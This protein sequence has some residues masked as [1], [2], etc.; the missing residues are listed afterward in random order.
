MEDSEVQEICRTIYQKHRRAL[1]VLFEHRPDRA[2]ELSDCLTQLITRHEDLEEDHCSKSYVR[3]IP[4]QLDF[5]PRVGEGWTR[6]GRMIL[7]E[8]DNSGGSLQLRLI[9]GPGDHKIREAVHR[10]V[11]EHTDVFNRAEKKFTQKWWSFHTEIWV[12]RKQYGE[13]EIEELEEQVTERFRRFATQDLTGIVNT[14]L[15]LR[16]L[17]LNPEH[18]L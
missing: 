7:F 9:L 17:D 3:F 6:S 13:L 8:L 11:S 14:L 5:L 15:E 4:R 10:L 1:D 18:P 2:S 16:T 12:S